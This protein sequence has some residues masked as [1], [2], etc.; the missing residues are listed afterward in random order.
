M[1]AALFNTIWTCFLCEKSKTRMCFCRTRK[2][3]TQWK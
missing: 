2:F 1:K 3:D